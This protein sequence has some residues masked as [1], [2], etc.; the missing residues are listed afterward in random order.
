MRVGAGCLAAFGAAHAQ[1]DSPSLLRPDAA[2]PRLTYP[3]PRP[4]DDSG[5]AAVAAAKE[6]GIQALLQPYDEATLPVLRTEPAAT[7]ALLA[8]APAGDAA[9]ARV[10][11]EAAR[12]LADALQTAPLLGGA[13]WGRLGG[14]PGAAAPRAGR[15]VAAEAYW[16]DPAGGAA[17]AVPLAALYALQ[18]EDLAL[19]L[20]EVATGTWGSPAELARHLAGAGARR[21]V[22]VLPSAPGAA[23]SLAAALRAEGVAV[24]GAGVAEDAG[25]WGVLQRLREARFPTL[26]ALLLEGPDF[27]LAAGGGGGGGDAM[28]RRGSKRSKTVAADTG[29]GGGEGQQQ[30]EGGGRAAARAAAL[31]ALEAA[32]AA[33]AARA[34]AAEAEDE[35]AG[36]GDEAA[37]EGGGGG[38][39]EA[40]EEDDAVAAAAAKLAEWCAA[41]GLD[42]E[43]GT[44]TLSA[45]DDAAAEP[46]AHACGVA[47]AAVAAKAILASG[48]EGGRGALAGRAVGAAAAASGLVA[49]ASTCGRT[50]TL[51]HPCP[52]RRRA[53]GRAGAPPRAPA[54]VAGRRAGR[55]AVGRPARGAHARRGGA[56]PHCAGDD[57]AAAAARGARHAAGVGAWGRERESG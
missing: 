30:R 33:E 35:A 51:P 3:I 49:K 24:A 37:A 55:C 13:A 39:R 41:N 32:S 1:A 5:A 15:G 47:R 38:G 25:R 18:P 56:V 21:A 22:C 48:G 46:L 20:P 53:L 31:G 16:V 14:A 26:P 10:A 4:Q 27:G 44:F 2:A 45:G 7:V 40:G 50:L 17:W 19:R 54:A 9:A 29:A 28:K 8:G 34:A 6:Q 43:F 36:T 57:G 42:A 11:L 12:T 52:P 23:G